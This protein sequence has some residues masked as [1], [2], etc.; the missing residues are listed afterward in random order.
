MSFSQLN[1]VSLSQIVSEK[2]VLKKNVLKKKKIINR[3]KVLNS[4]IFASF[5]LIEYVGG[6][7]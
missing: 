4:E 2:N 1:N 5:K 3:D 6:K 7:V